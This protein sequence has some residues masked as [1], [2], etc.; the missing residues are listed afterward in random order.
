MSSSL[1]GTCND[2]PRS[3]QCRGLTLVEIVLVLALLVVISAISLPLLDGTLSH[4]ALHSG[5]DLLRSAWS[6]ARLAAMQSGQT[7]V[8]RFEPEGSRFQIVALNELS[9][10][11][12]AE[13]QPDDPE[14]QHDAVD[15]LRLS[16]NRLPDGVVFAKGDVSTSSHLMATLPEAG[17]SP[18]SSPIL[19]HPDGTT[20]DASVLLT[21]NRPTAIRVTLRGLTGISNT[22]DVV[23]EAGP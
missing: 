21:N 15:V 12:V 8:F 16:L 4:A 22:I 2:A 14:A 19:F 1:D 18:W 20:S 7:Y 3:G 6:K 10:P 23:D 9:L 17:H 11:E 5:G 13:L